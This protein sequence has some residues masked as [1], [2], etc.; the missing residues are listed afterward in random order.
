M[1]YNIIVAG[2]GPA[3]LSAALTAGEEGFSVLL[4][5]L[6]RKIAR[7]NRPCCAMWLLEPGFHLRFGL[8]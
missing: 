1:S 5:D 7:H 2:A 8:Q 3:G 6:K 4:V